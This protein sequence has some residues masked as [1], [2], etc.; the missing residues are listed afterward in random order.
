[1]KGKKHHSPWQIIRKLEEA[2]VRSSAGQGI[3]QVC[4]AL[5]VA[6]STFLCR[7]NQYDGMKA[8]EARG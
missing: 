1:M 2:E 5:K 6:E 7:R 4:R 8:E 3:T